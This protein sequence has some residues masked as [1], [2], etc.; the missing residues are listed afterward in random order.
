MIA[1]LTLF[2][3]VI[4]CLGF[5]AMVLRIFAITHQLQ[6]SERLAWSFI[7]GMGLLGWL[8]FFVGV[9]G[10][11]TTLPLLILL[12]TGLCGVYF[13][14]L[15][16]DTEFSALSKLEIGLLALIAAVLILDCFEGVAPPGDADSLAY[17]FSLPKEFLRDQ[18]IVFVPRAIDGAVPLL[19]QMTYVPVLGLGGEKALTLWTMFTSWGVAF[20]FF[21]FCRGHL[22]RAWSLAI[23]LIWL[24]TPAVLYGGGS[25]QVEVRIA[26]FVILTIVALMK[27]KKTGLARYVAIAGMATGMFVGAKY[28]GLMFGGA[29]G[30][31]LFMIRQWPR[32]MLVFGVTSILL[33]FQWYYWNWV[34]TGDPLYPVLYEI[35]GP[36]NYHYWGPENQEHFVTKHFDAE[37]TLPNNPFWMVLYPF[38][39]TFATSPKFDSER[40]GL[41]PFLLMLAPFVAYGLW[42]FR[43]RVLSSQWL[44]PAVVVI[45]FYMIWYLTGSSQ[46]VRHLLPVYPLVLVLVGAVVAKLTSD[47]KLQ[48]PLIFASLLT[49][50]LQMAGN[51]ASSLNYLR[52]V[53]NNESK[54]DF[55]TRN[56]AGYEAVKWINTHLSPQDHILVFDRQLLFL[57]RSRTFFGHKFAQNRISLLPGQSDP[58]RF[59]GEL[60]AL[61]I[62]HILSFPVRLEQPNPDVYVDRGGFDLW[63]QLLD[64][65][66][67]AVIK[68]TRYQR[69]TSRSLSVPM[70]TNSHNFILQLDNSS[71][72]FER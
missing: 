55:L 19:V 32:Q 38:I 60:K 5:G 43:A 71:C 69:V 39:S 59:Y 46:R 63:K 23:V 18:K 36:E 14:G 62:T 47:K 49:I 51:G 58:A 33:G 2:L 72:Q 61:N 31:F 42:K 25:G 7:L 44:G 35:I 13:L 9:S 4:S 11:L 27:A 22:S 16:A 37:N 17:H 30:L 70:N 53:F 66:C 26:G 65:E 6:W 12:C 24:T 52:Y 20:V 48:L 8:V 40:N 64:A 1:V 21:T 50:G 45:S 28:T 68:K 54:D 34:H 3:Q 29:C 67:A 10:L 56:V 15:P 41:G 57:I